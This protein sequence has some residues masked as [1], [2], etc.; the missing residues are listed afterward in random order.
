MSVQNEIPEHRFETDQRSGD[1]VVIGSDGVG[2]NVDQAAREQAA[3]D[4]APAKK[5]V[6]R[7]PSQKKTP[8]KQSNKTPPDAPVNEAGPET[9]PA[10]AV[11]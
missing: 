5:V 4:A 2:V 10:D 8:K 6:V 1:T 7:K 3:A 9:G 11:T